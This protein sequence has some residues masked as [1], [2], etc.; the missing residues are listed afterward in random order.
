MNIF[1]I[2]EKI[3]WMYLL[4]GRIKSQAINQ[5]LLRNLEGVTFYALVKT[6]K[7]LFFSL[8]LLEM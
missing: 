7:S 4:K 3:D 2:A 1:V 8:R 6:L 5:N